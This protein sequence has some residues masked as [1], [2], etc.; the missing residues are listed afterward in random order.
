MPRSCGGTCTAGPDGDGTCD[1]GPNDL[2]CDAVVRANGDGFIKCQSNIDCDVGTIG[3]AA[4]N[5]TLAAGRECF[6]STISAEGTADPDTPVGA[7][8]FCIPPTSNAGINSVA[9]LP[10]PGR[11]LNQGR[12]RKFCGGAA[13]TEY[14]TNTGCP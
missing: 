6:L 2:S 10:G 8:I 13:G 14:V 5:C 12:T 9:G 7:A 3:I 1:D 11:V 4:G